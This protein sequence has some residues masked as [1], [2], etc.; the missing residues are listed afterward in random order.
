MQN[1]MFENWFCDGVS[2]VVS[3]I[4][5]KMLDQVNARPMVRPQTYLT[6]NLPNRDQVGINSGSIRNRFGFDSCSIQVRF[7]FDSGSIG[8]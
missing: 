5:T 4:Q 6:I 2:I 1:N 7:R 3:V 8:G